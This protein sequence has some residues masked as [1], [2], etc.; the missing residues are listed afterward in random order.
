MKLLL[1]SVVVCRIGKS[2]LPLACALV[3]SAV[4]PEID[5]IVKAT[6]G[7]SLL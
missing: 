5:V 7:L 3:T 6:G 1:K 2:A 4:P